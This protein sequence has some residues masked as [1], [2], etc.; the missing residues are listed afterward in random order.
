[1]PMPK[2]LTRRISDAA[3]D[4]LAEAYGIECPLRRD[5]ITALLHEINRDADTLHNVRLVTRGIQDTG[6]VSEW[7]R[8]RIREMAHVGE[9]DRLEA[10]QGPAPTPIPTRQDW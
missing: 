7:Q 4:A 8:R 9:L 3:I 5:R 2:P 1:M 10:R 6:G